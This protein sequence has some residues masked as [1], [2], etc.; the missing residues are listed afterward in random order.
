MINA[1][2]IE[3]SRLGPT[4]T[5]ARQWIEFRLYA[6]PFNPWTVP[7]LERKVFEGK[8]I[9]I[10]G[11]ASTVLD[12]L[13]DVNVDTYDIVVRLNNGITLARNCAGGHLGSRTDI[14]FHNL[15]E[16]GDRS[17]GE[18]PPGTL[19]SHGVGVCVFPHWTP[20]GS[21]RRVRR[22]RRQLDT[23]PGIEL[24]VLPAAF[25]TTLRRDLGNVPPTIGASA[26]LFCLTCDPKE[27]AIHGF[28]FF[29]TP[30]LAGYNERVETEVDARAWV[31]DSPVG[32]DVERE[33]VLVRARLDAARRDGL[34]ISLGRNVKKHLD[35]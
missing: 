5:R 22:K 2:R 32:H 6:A 17:A 4:L 16:H 27:L 28:T 9:I 11:P 26:I 1:T 33:R 20:V 18:I 23:V 25:A 24:K 21:K 14:L 7:V 13:H 19:R 8:R 15:V 12:D 31:A 35:R 30:Y 3:F 29:D 34:T 10:I